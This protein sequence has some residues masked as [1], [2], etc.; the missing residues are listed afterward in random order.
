MGRVTASQR[1][2]EA[3]LAAEASGLC[4]DAEQRRLLER[5]HADYTRV[6][7]QPTKF[8]IS[9]R[10]PETNWGGTERVHFRGTGCVY[11]HIGE[12]RTRLEDIENRLA[13]LHGPND[14]AYPPELEMSTPPPMLPD[15]AAWASRLRQKASQ[16][17]ALAAELRAL[18]AVIER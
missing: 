13:R 8:C 16:A 12:V 9:P 11:Y 4:D 3:R 7:R 10:C 17:E 5:L 14:I 6:L 2:A 1:A 15:A 18:A